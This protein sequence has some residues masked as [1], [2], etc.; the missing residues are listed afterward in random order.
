MI[1]KKIEPMSETI[2]KE[3][4]QLHRRILESILESQ[5]KIIDLLHKKSV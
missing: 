4:L 5:I 2:S 3:E 1:E